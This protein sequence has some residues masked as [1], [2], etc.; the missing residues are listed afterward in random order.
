MSELN[1]VVES[2]KAIMDKYSSLVEE[3]KNLSDE[4]SE[5][6]GNISGSLE[7][8]WNIEK[9]THSQPQAFGLDFQWAFKAASID[10]DREIIQHALVDGGFI[11]VTDGRRIHK[12]ENTENFKDGITGKD[13]EPVK[14]DKKF[15]GVKELIDVEF[16][17]TI[18][19]HKK[20]LDYS[21][22]RME[23]D[24]NKPITLNTSFVLDAISHCG[25]MFDLEYND[26]DK[27]R[28]NLVKISYGN[29]EAYIMPM[30][31]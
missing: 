20:G 17:H 28:Y 8:F 13:G 14:R 12:T 11:Y 29:K 24:I 3:V 31:Y 18:M 26:P 10:D 16:E 23:I 27:G 15:P 6:A 9:F 19:L 1:K 5:Q 30:N 21:S 22:N 25:G 7:S 2:A 4:L